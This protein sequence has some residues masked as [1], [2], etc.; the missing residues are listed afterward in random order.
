M[1]A[2]VVAVTSILKSDEK[3]DKRNYRAEYPKFNIQNIRECYQR[4]ISPLF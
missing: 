1:E 3:I 2:R 4:T